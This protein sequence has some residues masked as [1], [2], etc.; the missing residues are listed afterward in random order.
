MGNEPGSNAGHSKHKHK[1]KH[2]NKDKKDLTDFSLRRSTIVRQENVDEN[3]IA[4]QIDYIFSYITT[5]SYYT[6]KFKASIDPTPPLISNLVKTSSLSST[7]SSPEIIVTT[8]EIY[9]QNGTIKEIILLDKD[10]YV[11]C[12]D[13]K[14][15]LWNFQKEKYP[16]PIDLKIPTIANKISPSNYYYCLTKLS[17]DLFGFVLKSDKTIV[18]CH[19]EDG[20]K[21][22]CFVL[23]NE[24]D[25]VNMLY[26]GDWNLCTCSREGIISI[27]KI[28]RQ[29]CHRKMKDKK[30][31]FTVN[32]MERISEQSILIS[33][34][35]ANKSFILD[36]ETC[37]RKVAYDK[38]IKKVIKIGHDKCVLICNDCILTINT[39]TFETVRESE[40]NY[41]SQSFNQ[42]KFIRPFDI[43]NYIYFN[44]TD[45]TLYLANRFE[46]NK[47]QTFKCPSS[48]TDV[49]VVRFPKKEFV[50][51]NVHPSII[52][53]FSRSFIVLNHNMEV[54]S[55]YQE[56]NLY[57]DYMFKFN[58]ELYFISKEDTKKNDN[59][60]IFI[61]QYNS[62]KV[63]I[64]NEYEEC[65]FHKMK[66]SNYLIAY[67]INTLKLVNCTNG[68]VVQSNDS[69][70]DDAKMLNISEII[71]QGEQY[72]IVFVDNAF[73]LVN[74]DKFIKSDTKEANDDGDNDGD[75]NDDDNK[76]QSSSEKS[77]EEHFGDTIELEEG[78]NIQQ[79]IQYSDF[80]IALFVKEKIFTF[81]ME[82]KALDDE[83][84]IE[85]NITYSNNG[86]MLDIKHLGNGIICFMYEDVMHYY[87]LINRKKVEKYNDIKDSC[88]Y[89]KDDV[90]LF[91]KVQE[92]NKNAFAITQYN[93]KDEVINQNIT[94]QED[95]GEIWRN[96]E[97][98]KMFYAFGKKYFYMFNYGDAKDE[99]DENENDN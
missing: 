59:K 10:I 46:K 43:N 56:M 8:K 32:L 24:Y 88:P 34:W 45:S 30:M 57:F 17:H 96:M 97:D 85:T 29:E 75:D 35:K 50:G 21:P 12:S 58:N 19:I 14:I 61:L 89:D 90:F 80:K 44:Q 95:V 49:I 20:T 87:D 86:G 41:S 11:T 51:S 48:L 82:S 22:Y 27:W 78:E 67:G 2:K 84:P 33:D 93:I 15:D 26:L 76:S 99:Q 55:K 64:K 23:E 18:I 4:E 25:I 3:I 7:P 13:F 52:L 91:R 37:V 69:V 6:H 53:V 83:D 62:G 54:L 74:I 60:G 5:L 40:P 94:V 42:I 71:Y 66:K 77:F 9:Q 73:R 38:C 47:Y 16:K 92:G 36:I 98:D 72:L 39:T 68:E 70:M 65:K 81:D 63:V 79:V 31:Q 28:K 1:H